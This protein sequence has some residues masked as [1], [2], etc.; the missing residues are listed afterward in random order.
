M[1]T[2]TLLDAPTPGALATHLRTRRAR[3]ASVV[4]P[5]ELDGAGAPI[6]FVAGAGA[7]ALS[8]RALADALDQPFYGIQARGLEERAWP[9]RTT[10]RI[11]TRN[12]NALNEVTPD[13]P[14]LLG[15]YSFGGQI[16][17]A[18][19]LR[20]E[21][22]GRPP[23]LLVLLD[24]PCPGRIP[25]ARARVAARVKDEWSSEPGSTVRD[26]A[27]RVARDTARG[28]RAYGARQ[29]A[30]A[31]AGIVPRRGLAQYEL[32]LDLHTQTGLRY[33]PPRPFSG[34][35]LL[36]RVGE[37][38]P[39]DPRPRDFGWSR[40]IRGPITVVDVPG[41]H[42]SLL[43]PPAVTTAAAHIGSLLPKVGASDR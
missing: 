35:A 27:A 7:P 6:F 30:L 9:D 14:V 33:R 11:A 13:G 22:A 20:L 42:L 29:V 31:T 2:T 24:A 8:L 41:D 3:D 37:P 5:L 12:V 4:V 26:R 28:A 1:A 25:R 16:A 23:D 21:A 43:R 32:F 34:A 15:G 38:S 17:F 18:M 39:D 40:W 10:A 36:V 19:A